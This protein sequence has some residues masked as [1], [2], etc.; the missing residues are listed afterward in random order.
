MK[1][2]KNFIINFFFISLSILSGLIVCELALRIKH[3]IVPNYDI[4]MWKYAKK[5]KIK[6]KRFK[7]KNRTCTYKE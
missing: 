1:F 6:A 5:L 7:P 2:I 3:S 4:E